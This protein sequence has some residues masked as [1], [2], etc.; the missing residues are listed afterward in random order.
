[1]LIF[2]GSSFKFIVQTACSHAKYEQKRRFVTALGSTC[3]HG[4]YLLA[5]RSMKFLMHLWH[6][7]IGVI[8]KW[9]KQMPCHTL[10]FKSKSDRAGGGLL[11][12][13]SHTH[14]CH[15]GDQST[16]PVGGDSAKGYLNHPGGK[17]RVM[18]K[19]FYSMW[20]VGMRTCWYRR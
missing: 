15:T 16:C 12:V 8:F 6:K 2:F 9:V 10:H 13:Q 18:T 7:D 5:L 4:R 1:M 3:R 11:C 20:P 17:P 14:D 19:H